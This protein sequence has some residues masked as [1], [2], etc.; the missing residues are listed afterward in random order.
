MTMER[1]VAPPRAQEHP[2]QATHHGV[3][4]H[5]PY[6]WLR[7]PGYPSISDPGILAHLEAENAQAEAILQ[8]GSNEIA[9][10]LDEI[11]G[12]IKDD[13]QSV[14]ARDGAYEYWW[15]FEAGAQYRRWLR[16]PVAGGAEHVLL[17][18]VARAE[19][20]GYF[21]LGALEVSPDDRLLAWSE[22]ADGSERYSIH[23]RPAEG[24]NELISPFGNTSG[25]VIWS[26]DSQALVY[27]ELTPEHRPFRVRL[28]RLDA[29]AGSED[30][31]LYEETDPS[32][33]VG[34]D[35]TQGRRYLIIACGDHVTS[36]VRLIP[37]DDLLAEPILVSPRRA[38]HRYE[39]DEAGGDFFFRSNADHP[40]YAI[41]RAPADNPRET[42]WTSLMPSG[43]G[44]YYRGFVPFRR[45][46]AVQGREQGLDRVWLRVI[47]TR[48]EHAVPFPEDVA[49]VGLGSNAE[50][51]PPVIRL[52]YQSM[53]TPPTVFDYTPETRGLE[54]LKVQEIPSG[55]ER[56]RWRTERLTATASDGALV[57]ISIVYPADHP[58]DG[59]RPLYLYAY[60]AYGMGMPAGFSVSRLSLLERGFAFAIAHIRGGDEL[61]HA[62]YEGGKGA[63]RM[64]TFTDFI[65][66]AEHLIDSG[67]AKPGRIAI[68]GGSAGGT[69]MG[70]VLNLRPELWGSVAAH[71]PFVDV[72]NT[73]LDD[74]LPL[75]PIEWP[76]WGDPIRDAEAFRTILAYSPYENVRAQ[77]YPPLLVT[78]GLNDP[79]VTYWEPAKWVAKLRE[80]K[81]DSNDLLL[82]T[83]MG[84][85]HGGKSGRFE[86][87]RETAEEFAFILAQLGVAT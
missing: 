2:R 86:G 83:N 42:A 4:L 84:A 55:Y 11:K 71:V 79:R 23:V 61:G 81:T 47:A 17:D 48:A 22:D 38:N 18:E 39:I 58:R 66:C 12:R 8:P 74:T 6:H 21:R 75:T 34:I 19:G 27:V 78:A 76:E 50:I 25:G 16:R 40:D 64:T 46:L 57:P 44:R 28:R 9:T 82:K 36:E 37:L 7:D 30:A 33:F 49:A 63:H 65:A 62:W 67:F 13:D 72:L 85:G 77:D 26:A 29:A 54:T 15:R 73:M 56:M 31:I 70:T 24:G 80:L 10:V 5:D 1:K 69:L 51:D 45:W 43:A 32:F 53:I 35:R 87:L 41:L 14:P 68:S 52:S 20:R 60:G 3:D 59:S